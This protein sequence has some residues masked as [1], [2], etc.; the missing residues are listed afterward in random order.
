VRHGPYPASGDSPF[1][2]NGANCSTVAAARGLSSA[3][4]L[5]MRR[6]GFEQSKG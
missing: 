4:V 3:V 2:G 5:K 6:M 1:G